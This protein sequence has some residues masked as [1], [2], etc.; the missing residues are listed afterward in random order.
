MKLGAVYLELS[1]YDPPLKGRARYD[2]ETFLEKAP[3]T[4]P[5]VPEVRE[6]LQETR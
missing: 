2:M 1:K 4:D 5:E 3:P 6:L